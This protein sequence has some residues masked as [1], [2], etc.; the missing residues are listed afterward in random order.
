MNLPTGVWN[1]FGAFSLTPSA[2]GTINETDISISQTF[3]GTTIDYNNAVVSFN[4]GTLTTGYYPITRLNTIIT[5]TSVS[6]ALIYLNFK[7]LISSGTF[8][9]NTTSDSYT[10][11]YAVRIA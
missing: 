11:F 5:N 1:V 10:K 8:Q 3:G 6:T 9:L 2:S 7:I 4:S